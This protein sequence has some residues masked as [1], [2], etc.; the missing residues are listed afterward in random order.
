MI[1]HRDSLIAEGFQIVSL[2]MVWYGVSAAGNVIVKELLNEF[3]F[4]LTV[5]LVQLFSVWILSIPLLRIWKV[6][7]PDYLYQNRIYYFKIIIPLSIGKFL[8]QLSSHVSLWKVPVSYAHTVKATMPLFTVILS[9]LILREK[10][11]FSVYFSLVP[12]IVGVIIATVTE[13]SFNFIGLISALLSTFGFSLQNIYSKKSLKDIAIHHFTLLALLAKIS[14]CLFVPFWFFYDG[15]DIYYNTKYHAYN[16]AMKV[17]IYLSIDGILNFLHNVVAFTMISLVTP[18]SYSIANSTKRIVVICIS[19]LILRNP[20]T[21][22]N[23]I[24]MSLALFGVMYY[25]KAKY[26]QRRAQH[27]QAIIPLVRS[28]PN[29]HTLNLDAIRLNHPDAE[30]TSRHHPILHTSGPYYNGFIPNYASQ[31]YKNI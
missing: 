24:G 31:S 30:L 13:I 9:R 1:K 2:C 29:L 25:N 17:F 19:L 14:W 18:L 28:E 4:P 21:T 10:Q 16:R 22:A 15:I 7:P 8:A 12:I 3:P 26:D 27:K 20:V 11:S 23:V 5:T 6:P